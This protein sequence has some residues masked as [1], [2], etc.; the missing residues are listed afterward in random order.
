MT[1]ISVLDLKAQYQSIKDE[2]DAAVLGVMAS[3]YFVLGPNVKA[4]EAEVAEY[5][6]CRYGV[7]VASGTDALRLSLA[8]LGIGPG[9][10]VITTPFTFV[11]T[12]NT[13]S[14]SGARPVF[15]DIDPRTFN[16]VPAQIEAA[17]TERT[18]AIVP[19]HLYGQPAEMEAI[20]DIARRHSLYVIEDCAQ[21]IGAEADGRR[22]GSFG[23]VACFSFY[24]T[25]N[26]GA[27]GDGGMV[28]TNNS[29][30]AG[31]IDVLRRQGGKVKYYHE[32]LGFNSR[33]DEMQAALLR[34]K[35][36]HLDGWQAERRRVAA[37]YD[38]LLST[39]DVVTPVVRPGVTHV[40]HQY[41]I[42]VPRRDELHQF[43][44]DRG[45]GTMIYYPLP[46]HLQKLYHDLGYAE[47]S[48]P[49]SEEAGRKV[50]SLPMYPELTEEQIQR[51][52][53]AIAEFLSGGVR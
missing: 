25:K 49:V 18:K 43:L 11:A 50:L 10:E 9:D 31:R 12:A 30:I 28:T 45:I 34:V 51:V 8:V 4:L 3:G 47:G 46:L 44:K 5:V 35:L 16:I 20:M 37:R 19:V 15:V 14:H 1:T 7:G 6:G 29:E 21:A 53:E 36:R 38:E 40:Y 32:V 48:L 33:L 23:D 39:L 24:P 52:V 27:Y 17:V 22:V 2:I 41:T 26:L 42:R 13:I